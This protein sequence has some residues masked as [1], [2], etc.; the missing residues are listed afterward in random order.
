MQ[1]LKT[2]CTTSTV[3]LAMIMC[4]YYDYRMML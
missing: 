4:A 2:C 1:F 3:L